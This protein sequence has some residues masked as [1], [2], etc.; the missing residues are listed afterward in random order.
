MSNRYVK[1][2]KEEFVLRNGCRSNGVSAQTVASELSN[3]YVTNG[4]LTAPLVVDS[5]RP[6]EAPLH[7]I[8]E[9]DDS[10]A[11][12]LY[13]HDQARNVIRSVSLSNAVTKT[14]IPVYVHVP[15]AKSPAYHPVTVVVKSIT[16]YE[17]AFGELIKLV[18]SARKATETLR[19]AAERSGD[20]DIE[21]LA[22][23][24]LVL[25][26]MQTAQSAVAAL[27]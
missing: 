19:F 5:A 20:G 24:N 23:I 1:K 3:I 16:Q 4:Q 15:D 6:E 26:A 13:R 11:G 14:E 18:E 27:H 10:K 21:K 7:P 22:R 8:F 9:W 12:E 17:L 2:I 25:I